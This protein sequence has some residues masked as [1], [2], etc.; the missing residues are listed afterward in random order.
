MCKDQP[1][2]K[3]LKGKREFSRLL[4]IQAVCHEQVQLSLRL[5][6]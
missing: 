6:I 2:E 1:Q 4:Q 3:A 5:I